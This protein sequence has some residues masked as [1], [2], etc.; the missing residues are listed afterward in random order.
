VHPSLSLPCSYIGVSTLAR[1]RHQYPGILRLNLNR[2]LL[3][4]GQY[5]TFP[6]RRVG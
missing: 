5:G 4:Y 2:T 6:G 3:D 1:K